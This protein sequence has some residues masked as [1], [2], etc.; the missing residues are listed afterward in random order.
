MSL[1]KFRI[2]RYGT[3]NWNVSAVLHLKFLKLGLFLQFAV[4]NREYFA[5]FTIFFLYI[6][7]L[8]LFYESDVDLLKF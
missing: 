6:V 7:L 1:Q 8:N 3:K 2:L 4:L 5:F